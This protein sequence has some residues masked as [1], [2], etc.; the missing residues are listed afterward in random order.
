MA[1]LTPAQMVQLTGRKKPKLQIAW[2]EQQ[3][4]RRGIH[5][6]VNAAGYPQVLETL[7]PVKA[8]TDFE[9]GEVG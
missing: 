1:L 2:L 6:F 3:G 4:L 7:L 9:L 5:F 8:I